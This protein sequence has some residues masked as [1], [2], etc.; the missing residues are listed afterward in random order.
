MTIS[1][2]VAQLITY[3]LWFQNVYL[4]LLFLSLALA[5]VSIALDIS[6]WTPHPVLKLN[7]SKPNS[8]LFPSPK[9]YSSSYIPILSDGIITHPAMQT[10]NMA[11][12]LNVMNRPPHLHHNTLSWSLT[13]TIPS[14]FWWY[15]SLTHVPLHSQYQLYTSDTIISTLNH[16][17]ISPS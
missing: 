12:I 7:I 17:N 13:T 4:Y 10:R 11:I 3:F 1:T 6:T 8:S 2:A 5:P 14:R 9:A 16:C 15:D